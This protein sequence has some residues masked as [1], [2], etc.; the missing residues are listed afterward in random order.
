MKTNRNRTL[1]DEAATRGDSIAD[2]AGHRVRWTWLAAAVSACA[3]MAPA[4]ASTVLFTTQDD[5]AQWTA[6]SPSDLSVT[7]VSS[8][9]WDGLTTNGIGDIGAAGAAGLTGSLTVNTLST[10][11]FDS[12]GS[13]GE[14]G[15]TAF[16][17]A[18]TSATTVELWYTPPAPVSGSYFN[19]PI[20]LNYSD[21]F[22]I[23]A[24][25]SVVDSGSGYN[26]ATYNFATAAGQI[27]AQQSGNGIGYFELG[28]FVNSDYVNST[29]S[30]DHITTDAAPEPSSAAMLIM[31]GIAVMMLSRQRN[32]GIPAVTV[33]PGP[34]G[35]GNSKSPRP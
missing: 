29:F 16:L 20:Y 35:I 24:P 17:N 19:L 23:I 6:G 5:F 31:G 30:V 18:L 8:P 25:A 2:F 3:L 4:T 7:A 14:S 21:H 15:N 33:T 12:F 11:T 1:L 26:I 34:D 13:P 27:A 28:V 9:D 10:G 32:G 22:T